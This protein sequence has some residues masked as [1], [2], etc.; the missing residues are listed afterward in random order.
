MHLVRVR[1]RE[2]ER[3]P[4]FEEARKHVRA[5]WLTSETRGLRAAAER[6]APRYRI[7]LDPPTRKALS[8]A[9]L[10][11]PLLGRQAAP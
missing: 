8:G 7:E 3:V 4:T 11:A 1:Q 9:P 10:L 2:P 5:D 6:L